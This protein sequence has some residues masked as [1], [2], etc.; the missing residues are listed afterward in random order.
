MASVRTEGEFDPA[1]SR[2]GT[3]THLKPSFSPWHLP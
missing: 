2:V 1:V 3:C